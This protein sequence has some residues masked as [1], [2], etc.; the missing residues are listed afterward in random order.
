MISQFLKAVNNNS[1]LFHDLN[2]KSET[3]PLFLLF[4]YVYKAH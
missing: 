4:S 3:Y 1:Q 2:P